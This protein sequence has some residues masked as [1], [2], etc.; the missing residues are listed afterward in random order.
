MAGGMGT[1]SPDAIDRQFG[2]RIRELRLAAG[3]QQ[4]ALAN[5]LGISFQQ[6]QQ[7]EK[8]AIRVGAGR[9]KKIAEALDL[10][11]TSLLAVADSSDRRHV[12]RDAVSPLALLQHPGALRLLR[13]Y[14]KLSNRKM[15]SMVVRMVEMIAADGGKA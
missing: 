3:M 1:K 9:L 15:R 10:P 14:A 13:A 11:V 12:T 2:R 4:K 6:L 8:G 5:R 7:Y